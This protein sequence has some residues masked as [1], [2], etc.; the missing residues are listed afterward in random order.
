M[1]PLTPLEPGVVFWGE[2]DNLAEVRS[3]GVRCGQLITPGGMPLEPQ[4]GA[5]HGWPTT[6][7]SSPFSR[8][9]KAR[10]MPTFRPSSAPSG[11]SRPPRGT[12]ASAARIEVSDFAKTMGVASIGCHIGCVPEDPT[13]PGLRG[14]PRCRPPHLRPRRAQRPD[15][16]ARDR[17]GAR[18]RPA[19]LYSGCRPAESAD[20]FRSGQHDPL[21]QRRSDRGVARGRS[22][23]R[24]G[25]CEG[26]RLAPPH[27]PGALGTERP[28]GQGAVGMERFVNAFAR[29]VTRGR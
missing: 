27:V 5:S 19:A 14:C 26:R 1:Q 7:P 13:A 17:A 11:S 6:S 8:R 9:M 4:H 10:T 18:G 25:A 12:P 21:R 20:Q 29:S 15:L 22:P 24:V 2:R 23:R 28:L 3:L 16:R